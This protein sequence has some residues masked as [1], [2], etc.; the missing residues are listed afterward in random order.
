MKKYTVLQTLPYP[1]YEITLTN[2]NNAADISA[3]MKELRV[4]N[5]VYTFVYQG[6]VIKHGISVDKK[7]NFGD[8]IYRQAGHLEGWRYRL[9]GP[10][11]DDMR[12][13]DID[14]YSLDC[15]ASIRVQSGNRRMSDG[16]N[17]ERRSAVSSDH[18]STAGSLSLTSIE[19]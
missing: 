11:G 12:Q 3:V 4:V 14:Y 15:E 16:S 2:L 5:Y 8:R 1:V 9:Q 18:F 19:H 13:I 17:S 6:T 10:N 7:S